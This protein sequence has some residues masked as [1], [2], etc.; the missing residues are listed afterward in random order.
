MS[1]A[2]G[3]ELCP[4]ARVRVH[5]VGTNLPA[6]EEL[7]PALYNPQG[8]RDS[9][10]VRFAWQPSILGTRS[11]LGKFLFGVFACGWVTVHWTDPSVVP[12]TELPL[13]VLYIAHPMWW[14]DMQCSLCQTA[15]E[16]SAY[17]GTPALLLVYLILQKLNR[18]GKANQS[19]ENT[20][21]SILNLK[22]TEMK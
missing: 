5:R 15:I 16:W 2:R 6:V 10:P 3:V 8:K 19:R 21:M 4:W 17:S 18:R 7:F 14:V 9:S 11:F 22:S 1:I 20:L 13:S 12:L